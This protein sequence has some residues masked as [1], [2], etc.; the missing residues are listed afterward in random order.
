MIPDIWIK[1]TA[2]KSIPSSLNCRGGS[3]I[4]RREDTARMEFKEG[5]S[6]DI[7]SNQMRKQA[8]QRGNR[9][10]LVTLLKLQ[11]FFGMSTPSATR[12][13]TKIR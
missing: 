8:R 1:G 6:V 7:L 4:N 13:T 11:L 5:L 3:G 9:R 10:V 12:K 2:G